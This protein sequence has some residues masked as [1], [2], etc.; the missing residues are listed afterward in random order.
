[1]IFVKGKVV[2]TVPEH[3]IVDTLIEHALHL[4]EQQGITINPDNPD[5]DGDG[6]GGTGGTGPQITVT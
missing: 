6:T 2:A 5:G 1:Q 3:H 4:A